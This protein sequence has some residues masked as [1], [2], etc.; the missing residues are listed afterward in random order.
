MARSSITQLAI[1]AVSAL[2]LAAGGCATPADQTASLQWQ[3]NGTQFAQ[4]R[5]SAQS[6]YFGNAYAAESSDSD[7]WAST[8]SASDGAAMSD[9]GSAAGDWSER[10]YVYR[11]GR[12][13]KTGLALNRM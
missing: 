13:P 1:V 5:T 3:F 9:D 4:E 6:A 11:G 10:T 2:T 12:D 7:S 8:G